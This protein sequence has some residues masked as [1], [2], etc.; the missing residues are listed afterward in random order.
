MHL[1]SRDHNHLLYCSHGKILES[2]KKYGPVH[3]LEAPRFREAGQCMG[4][5]FQLILEMKL[6]ERV[7]VGLWYDALPK[8]L[9]PWTRG[10]HGAGSLYPHCCNH[11]DWPSSLEDLLNTTLTWIPVFHNDTHLVSRFFPCEVRENT[12]LFT[13][14]LLVAL[15]V[16]TFWELSRVSKCLFSRISYLLACSGTYCTEDSGYCEL[17]RFSSKSRPSF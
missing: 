14:R 8:I 3:R 16:V 13:W 15:K 4:G 9:I 10:S 7:G 2:M 5:A 1:L 17:I 6:E 12:L 11:G